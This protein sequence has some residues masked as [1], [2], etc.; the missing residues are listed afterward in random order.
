MILGAYSFCFETSFPARFV[1]STIRLRLLETVED[2]SVREWLHGFLGKKM[3]QVYVPNKEVTT[4]DLSVGKAIR[5]KSRKTV[6][7]SKRKVIVGY[8]ITNA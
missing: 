4:I 5:F 1:T 2:S 6:M 8:N 3:G 7:L